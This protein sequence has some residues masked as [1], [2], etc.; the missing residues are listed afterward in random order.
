MKLHEIQNLLYMCNTFSSVFLF[1]L[2][3]TK[4]F[5]KDSEIIEKPLRAAAAAAREIMPGHRKK[6]RFAPNRS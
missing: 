6:I 2:R 5:R 1:P 3:G 4:H